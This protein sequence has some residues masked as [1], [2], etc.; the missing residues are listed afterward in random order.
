M[1]TILKKFIPILTLGLSAFVLFSSFRAPVGGECFEIYQDG[2]MVLQRCGKN[3]DV[4][5]TISLAAATSN[6]DLTVKY[7]HCGQAGKNR[8][9]TLK[10]SE[11]TILK[12]WKFENTSANAAP[13]KC[14]I[15]EIMSM[16]IP[17]GSGLKLFYSSSELPNGRLLAIIKTNAGNV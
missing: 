11:G 12:E 13:M 7:Y 6:S 14:G 4:V 1:K 5:Q 16:K 17:S 2:K 15:K 3:L 9:L 10:N 8:T